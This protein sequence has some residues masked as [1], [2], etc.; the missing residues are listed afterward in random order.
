MTKTSFRALHN[1]TPDDA[2]RLNTNLDTPWPVSGSQTLTHY[3]KDE[4][5]DIAKRVNIWTNHKTTETL[6][7]ELE[8]E[9]IN[10]EEPLPLGL[11]ALAIAIPSALLLTLT[12]LL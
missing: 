12:A 3:G 2:Q 7:W 8:Y 9:T 6:P 1:I 11:T 4:L 10:H 5:A